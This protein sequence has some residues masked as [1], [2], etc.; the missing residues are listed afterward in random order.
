LE[1][2]VKSTPSTAALAYLGDAVFELY[3]RE[4]L[5][6]QN[7]TSAS[8]QALN[9]KARTYV[10][11]SAQA[12]MYHAVFPFLNEAEQAVM[13][14]GRNLH[15]ASRAKNADAIS[16]RHATGLEA[17]FGYL[18]ERGEQERVNELFALCIKP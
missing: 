17:L 8:T 15:A 6:S 9:R 18:Y 16:Y 10:S 1:K 2:A 12:A 4:M 3:V 14:R 11:A 13:K 5:L 7:E